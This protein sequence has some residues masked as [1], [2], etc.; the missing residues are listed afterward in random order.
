MKINSTSSPLFKSH[1]INNKFQVGQYITKTSKYS[2]V[3]VPFVK[4][5]RNNKTDMKALEYAAEYWEHDKYAQ[6]I[7]YDAITMQR[8]D[9][10]SIYA[11]TSQ[12]F[13]IERHLDP[14]KILGLIHVRPIEGDGLFI[15][16]IQVNPEYIYNREPKHKGIGSAILN[17]LKTMCSKIMCFP[18]TE[19]SVKN[20][21]KKNGFIEIGE[22]TN[23]YV[24][25]K[26]RIL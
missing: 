7:Y 18:A 17:S 5:D 1:Y 24:W 19:K 23:C 12:F 2:N 4:I 10:S 15:E 14:E 26:N 21:Y 3:H 11:L 6:N 16:H 20:F 8:N 25:D 13:D 22:G 9:K